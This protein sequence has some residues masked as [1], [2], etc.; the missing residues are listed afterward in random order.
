MNS[1]FLQFIIFLLAVLPMSIFAQTTVTGIVLDSETSTPLIGVTVQE[2][3]TDRGTV[4][5]IDGR[6]MIMVDSIDPTLIFRYTGYAA[7]EIKLE[8]R[9]ELE[10]RMG[11]AAILIDQ[12]VVVGYG[13]QKKSDL[14]GAVS[15]VK[16]EDISRVATSN[17]EQAL[18][19]KVSGVYVAPASGT[20]GAGAVIRI[21]GTGTL[22]NAS[23]LYVVDGM[24]TYDAST[25]NPEDVESVEVLKD[26]SA[27]AIY[28]SRGAN[29]V[30]IITTKKGVPR[31]RAYI[32]GSAYYGT[33]EVTKQI[34][35]L[36]ATEFAQAYN[37][38][39]GQAFFPDPT[40]FG[41]GTNW[42]DEIYQMAPIYNATVSANGGSEQY[43]YNFS[44]NYFSQDGIIKNSHFDRLT[45]RLNAEYKLTPSIRLGHNMSYSNIREDVSPGVVVSAYHMPPIY[46][47]IDSTGDFSDPTFFGLAIANP[48]ADLYYKSN[49]NRSGTR[50]FG[51]LYVDVDFL[52]NFTFRSNFGTDNRH[53][54]SSFFEPKFQV[55]AS[56]LN[57]NDR[58]SAESSEGYE[59]IWEQTLT[60]D[61]TWDEHHITALVGYTAEERK[62]E[63][64][65]GSREN[66]PGTAE[67]LLFLSAGNDTTQMNFQSAADEA[68]NS[69]LYRINYTLKDKY[70]LTLSWRTDRSSRFTKANRTA[71][72]PSGSVGWNI[73]A[74]DFMSDF[75][76]I[77]RFKLRASYGVLGN[78]AASS[79][80]PSTGAV[81]GGLYGIFGPD[82]NLNQGATLTSLSNS[83]L[84]WET[85]RQT[86]IGM[87]L[88]LFE[89][90]FD[91]EVDYYDR[92]TYDIIAAVPIP[93]YVGSQDD[94]VVNT[95][96]VRNTGWDIST[97]WR[98]TT[99]EFSYNLG[100][101]LSPVKNNV[102]KLAEGRSEIFSAFLQGDPATHT[103][104][105]LPIGSFYGYKVAGIFQSQEEIDASPKLGGEKPGD[106][107][108]EDTNG[109]NVLN[110][111]DRV[112]LG[113][114]IPTLTY[115]FTAG[116]D[117]KGFDFNAD[118]VGSDGNKVFNAKETFRFAVYNWENHVVDRW[119]EQNHSLTEP[120]ITN[121]GNNYRVSDRFLEDG[122]FIRLRS[123]TLG[124]SLPR[125]L[126]SKAKMNKVR[127]YITGT[128]VWTDQS[129]SGY[130]P[131]FANAENSYE[132][133]F[134]FGGYPI[135]KSWIGGIEI[136]F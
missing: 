109:D 128:N 56:Q 59:W 72:F 3:S 42:Q 33:Q 64:L 28:G 13:I 110:G 21:R 69:N 95:A 38:L 67:E 113:S 1:K 105:G 92:F 29:G 14:T 103:I 17:V 68:L 94:P 104:V 43:S 121:G 91:V 4:T 49:N 86:D 134:D 66:F 127:F 46:P 122:S 63:T 25:V 132:V 51:N 112:Y 88:S 135:A 45:F 115:S 71:N 24:I 31:D 80:Y 82:E 129:Y 83:N 18:Q 57:L 48:A 74:E 32:T 96:E 19:G 118:I 35:M 16:G 22:N 79:T 12:I 37:E 53:R 10:V 126:L 34:S 73:G 40:V 76:W 8:G 27:A 39:R 47:P 102:E 98:Q 15:T 78:Q 61:R 54:K 23:P 41:E 101:I 125:D 6:F 116:L 93:E 20:P 75:V 55:S 106:I 58:L 123:I 52:K 99:G 87:E 111:D 85:S 117:W 70:L 84:K 2:A 120:R 30:I 77:D 131:E 81:S 89:G 108:F 97:I 44:T 50:L 130:S 11:E 107:R 90:K 114:P 62:F 136:Q 100:L 9:T 7:V 133:G 119:T 26:A 36:N 124:Y 60:Y 5:D 65:G